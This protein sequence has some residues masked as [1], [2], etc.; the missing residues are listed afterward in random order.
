MCLIQNFFVDRPH[1]MHDNPNTASHKKN[2]T[3]IS[4][5]P[6]CCLA[7]DV[8]DLRDLVCLP[9]HHCLVE[10][11][12]TSAILPSSLE[13]N[14]PSCK[15][16]WEFCC[17]CRLDDLQLQLR[18]GLPQL[19]KLR[20]RVKLKWW[21]SLCSSLNVAL[22]TRH[23]A[24]NSIRCALVLDKNPCKQPFPTSLACFNAARR[25]S[26]SGPPHRTDPPEQIP[27]LSPVPRLLQP[28]FGVPTGRVPE[29]F[30]TTGFGFYC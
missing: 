4:R 18:Y 10:I 17:D 5:C 11:G 22:T 1:C 2:T 6:L 26:T 30:T 21:Q 29:V 24:S 19:T 14:L 23:F 3:E 13:W 20:L 12:L 27:T 8:A 9:C 15:H 16:V 28:S 25:L 7:H